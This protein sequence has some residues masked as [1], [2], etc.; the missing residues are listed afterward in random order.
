[1]TLFAYATSAAK[2]MKLQGVPRDDG[3]HSARHS[4]P[5]TNVLADSGTETGSDSDDC[6]VYEFNQSEKLQ[7]SQ[8]NEHNLTC[9]QLQ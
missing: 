3:D 8:G 6:S 2:K 9:S 4:E 5:E 7:R 1:M